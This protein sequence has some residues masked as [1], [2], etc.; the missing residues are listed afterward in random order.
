[1]QKLNLTVLSK[2]SA[3]RHTSLHV[4]HTNKGKK[5]IE[6]A[7]TCKFGNFSVQGIFYR[8]FKVF[9]S[10]VHVRLVPALKDIIQCK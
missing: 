1:M 5:V 9:L 7:N 2:L 6:K 3:F 4:S 8:A 10:T